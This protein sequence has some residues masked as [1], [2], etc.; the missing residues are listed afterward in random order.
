MT[1]RWIN[2]VL[3]A[4]VIVGII[5]VNIYER[6]RLAEERADFLGQQMAQP[7]ETPAEP[8]AERDELELRPREQAEPEPDPEPEPPSDD[9]ELEPEDSPELGDYGV[10][11][12]HPEAVQVGM[13]VLD[14]GGNAVDSAISVAYAL[15]VVE[16]FGSGLGG[17][18]TMLIHE[19]DGTA[20][21]YDYRETAPQSGV[22]PN[23]NIGVPGFVAGMEVI[24]DAHGTIEKPDLIEPAARFAED[25]VT[26]TEYLHERLSDASYRMPVH[27]SPELFPN[28]EPIEPDQILHQPAYGQALRQIQEE[29]QAAFYEGGLGQQIVDAVSGLEM[30]DFAAYEVL[31]LEPTV[32]TFA[33]YE[34]ISGA[35]PASGQAL[36]QTLQ[37]AEAA[38]INDIELGTTEAYHTIAQAWRASMSDRNEFVGDPSHEDV[39]VDQLLSTEHAES[40]AAQIP[41]DDFLNVAEV[42]SALSTE[43]DTTHVVVV[44]SEGRMVSMTNTLSNFFGSGLPVSGFFL[45]DQLKN[46]AG[47]P[48]S[49]NATAPGKRPRSFVTPTIVAS[50]GDA[51]LGI[52]SPG[53]RRIPM[54]TAQVLIGWAGQGH[55]LDTATEAARF[56]L[57]GNE[58]QVEQALET[59]VFNELTARGYVITEDMPTTEYFG[60]MQ[61]LLVDHDAGQISGVADAR[62][63]GAWESASQSGE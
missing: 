25:G 21:A 29:G 36:I 59:E 26:V 20:V 23:S 4:V 18:G 42:D 6:P 51:V 34:V 46:F 52:G 19:P 58:M 55:D 16:P 1:Q 50:D 24:H 10:T 54:V 5:V 9:P 15:G 37:I 40:I 48:E 32:G 45:N 35:A 22:R 8:P 7:D 28:G 13:D 14:A 47:D 27:L 30:D 53:G 49:V 61:A 62:R 60:G 2:Y 33:G 12:S 43:T 39:P 41:A 63:D 57:E 38:G 11:A 3:G 31:E 17:G 44:D 56:H